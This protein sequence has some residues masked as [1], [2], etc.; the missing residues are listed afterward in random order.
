MSKLLRT[1]MMVYED[2]KKEKEL[3]ICLHPNRMK[4]LFLDRDYNGY[5]ID[6]SVVHKFSFDEKRLYLRLGNCTLAFERVP[7]AGSDDDYKSLIKE[8]KAIK[9]EC[10]DNEVFY[11]ASFLEAN[12]SYGRATREYLE[13]S[14]VELP[15]LQKTNAEIEN[16]VI[17]EFAANKARSHDLQEEIDAIT[18]RISE[19]MEAVDNQVEEKTVE[20]TD[21]E[22][23]LSVEEIMREVQN[24]NEE[25]YEIPDE[26]NVTEA[27]IPAGYHMV[28]GDEYDSVIPTYAPQE[29]VS[30]DTIVVDKN[31][32]DK[33]DQD[34]EEK[35]VKPKKKKSKGFLQNLYITFLV[36]LIIALLGMIALIATGNLDA[37]IDLLPIK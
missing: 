20:Q 6:L 25:T 18:N 13:K 28:G 34:V 26:E 15:E 8:M 33:A 2:H 16:T 36:L 24:M 11:A 19:E 17:A 9:S 27:K 5:F 1:H 32:I 37:L 22:P 3:M 29:D 23:K 4:M 14:N 21:E 10:Q 30:G 12:E 7:G 31:E 35:P